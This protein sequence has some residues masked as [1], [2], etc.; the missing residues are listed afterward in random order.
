M[1]ETVILGVLFVCFFF[2]DEVG[3]V[4]S[5]IATRIRGGR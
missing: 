1:I 2:S 3:E 4:I 5:A